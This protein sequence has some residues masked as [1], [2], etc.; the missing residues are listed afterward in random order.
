MPE[1]EGIMQPEIEHLKRERIREIMMTWGCSP[2]LEMISWRPGSE[3]AR[4]ETPIIV[5]VHGAGHTAMHWQYMQRLFAQAGYHSLAVNLRGHGQSEGRSRILQNTLQEYID[6]VRGFLHEQVRPRPYVLIGHSMGGYIVQG[7]CQ[8]EQDNTPLGV[9]L[10]ASTTP[11]LSK[12]VGTSPELILTLLRHPGAA[13]HSFR[14]HDTLLRTAQ[15]VRDVFFSPQAAH[16]MV[17]FCFEHMQSESLR[18]TQQFKQ[19]PSPEN[20][21]PHPTVSVLIMG[22]EQDKMV[23]PQLVKAT[24]DA[25]GTTPI[26]FPRMGHDLMLDADHEEVAVALMDWIEHLLGKGNVQ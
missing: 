21:G 24:A 22:A 2:Q 3:A 1:R 8:Q 23:P 25:Y 16:E 5:L 7:V 10:L 4:P 20:G 9:A 13:L 6:D 15:Q 18:P 26:M 12:R 11:K 14:T 19:F 17:Q